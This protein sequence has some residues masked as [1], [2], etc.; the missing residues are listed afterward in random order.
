MG[1]KFRI[2]GPNNTLYEGD[3]NKDGKPHG[4]GEMRY[5]DGSTFTGVFEDGFPSSGIFL[6]SKTVKYTGKIKDMQPSGRGIL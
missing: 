2:P 1:N 3:C 5:A 4:N 6:Y